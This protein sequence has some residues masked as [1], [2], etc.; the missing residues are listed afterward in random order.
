M[1]TKDNLSGS[2][3]AGLVL[4]VLFKKMVGLTWK[5]WNREQGG[6]SSANYQV[7]Y[8]IL[9]RNVTIIKLWSLVF[10]SEQLH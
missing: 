10:A 4:E 9:E 5:R 6:L 7:M 1:T 3:L 2:N 8:L